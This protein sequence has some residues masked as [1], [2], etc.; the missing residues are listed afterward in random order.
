MGRFLLLLITRRWGWALIGALIIVGGVLWGVSS[1]LIPYE[2]SLLNSSNQDSVYIGATSDGNIYIWTT[3]KT[4]PT[5][6]VARTSDFNPPIDRTK[7]H[8]DSRLNF[9][10]RSDTINLK[11][12]LADNVHVTQAHIIEQL[13]IYDV[14]S[15]VT[16]T[17]NA[18]GYD[19]NSSGY[20]D[21]RW[22]P[23]GDATIAFGL[24]VA[25][26]AL[27]VR[28]KKRAQGADPTAPGWP[29]TNIPTYPTTETTQNP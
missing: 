12:T 16:A 3:D 29:F 19:P 27:F 11:A 23:G 1:P 17:Y 6:Y 8:L 7:I 28:R 5:F 9:V 4:N 26:V 14:N 21:S 24:L 25:C 20:L 10:D 18:S 22:W 15:K 13:V 2:N